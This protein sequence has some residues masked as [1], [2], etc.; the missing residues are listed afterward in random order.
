MKKDKP[1]DFEYWMK[2]AKNDPEAFEKQRSSMIDAFISDVPNPV[3]RDRL[4]KLQWRVERE[5][6]LAKNPM[7]AAIRIYDMMWESLGKNIEAFQELADT[8]AGDL[9]KQK[10]P[11]RQIKEEARIL[12][13]RSRI[14]S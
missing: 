3:Q 7:D 8:L 13:F 1:F 5:R 14:G 10:I 6:E 2:L 4:G 12:P 11:A 9:L